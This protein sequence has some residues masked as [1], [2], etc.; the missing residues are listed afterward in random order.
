M[1]EYLMKSTLRSYLGIEKE[2]FFLSII[3][4]AISF[5]LSYVAGDGP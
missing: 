4:L 1:E 3:L 2:P 5:E